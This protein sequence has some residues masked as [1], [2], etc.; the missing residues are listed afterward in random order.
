MIRV[1]NLPHPIHM[2]WL[3]ALHSTTLEAR[4]DAN[5]RRYIRKPLADCRWRELNPID[6]KYRK[7]LLVKCPHCNRKLTDEELAS[8]AKWSHR[9][10]L[11]SKFWLEHVRVP[12]AIREAAGKRSPVAYWVG[13]CDSC[14]TVMWAPDD[15]KPAEEAA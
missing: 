12:P 5:E 14:D 7:S 11:G 9:S 4:S 3:V 8:R 10:Q 2:E 15:G 6:P 1:N 13:R